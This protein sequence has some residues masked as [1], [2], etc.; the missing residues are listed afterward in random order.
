MG[1][2]LPT[3]SNYRVEAPM[4]AQQAN[5]TRPQSSYQLAQRMEV[6]YWERHADKSRNHH[7]LPVLIHKAIAVTPEEAGTCP[8]LKFQGSWASG[9]TL[10]GSPQGWRVPQLSSMEK[11]CVEQTMEKCVPKGPVEMVEILMASS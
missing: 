7:S 11:D 2:L 4:E 9:A 1:C 6:P 3:A 10:E 5:N 8:H